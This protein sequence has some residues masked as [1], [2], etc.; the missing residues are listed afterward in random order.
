ML[1]LLRGDDL[2]LLTN[3][4]NDRVHALLGSDDR[5]LAV[6][7]FEGDEY[8]IA[9]VVD[10]AQTMPFLT[11]LRIVV[12]REIGRFA[13]DDLAAIV[14]YLDDPLPTTALLLTS[15][16]GRLPKALLDALKKQGAEIVDTDPPTGKARQGWLD[17]HFAAAPIRLDGAGRSLITERLGEDLARL[18]ALFETLEATYGTNAKVSA[19]DIEPF[20]GEGGSVPPWELTDAIDRG[21]TAGALSKLGRMMGAGGRH[22]LQMMA[23]LHGHYGR[24][25]R[26]DGAEVYDE[27][28][29]AALLGMKGS[30]FPAKKALDQT[31]RLGHEG[32]VRAIELLAD[33]DLDLRG[34]TDWP[35]TLVMEVLVARLA[36]LAPSSS[37]RRAPAR[38]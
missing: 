2:V 1:A 18:A 32:V 15:S 30:T 34:R 13:A 17:E 14:R 23:T 11:D 12:A 29:A 16:G 36:R 22:P 37:A 7:D 9:D 21:D 6:S 38:R 10:A 31:R 8:T 33:A 3:E 27:K 4:L 26:L 24:M 20:L 25:L 35:D 28:A 19:Q 5:S